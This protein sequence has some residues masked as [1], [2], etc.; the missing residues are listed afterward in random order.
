LLSEDERVK[1]FYC[2]SD[3]VDTLVGMRL[4]GIEGEVI[5]DR[6]VFLARLE[7]VVVDESVAIVLITTNLIDLAPNVVSELKLRDTNSLIVEIPDRH[8]HSK[9]GEKIDAYVSKAVGVNLKEDPDEL[10]K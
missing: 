2:L 5:H 7:Q 4:V 3:N 6:D 9:I 10:S 8:G 1:K